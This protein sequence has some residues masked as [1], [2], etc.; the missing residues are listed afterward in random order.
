MDE[1][2]NTKVSL[3]PA[4]TF[5]AVGAFLA[6]IG[7]FVGWFGVTAVRQTAIFGRE[8]VR[9]DTR[10]GTEDVTGILVAVLG[11]LSGVLAVVALAGGSRWF[12]RFAASFAGFGGVAM[13]ASSALGAVRAGTVAQGTEVAIGR[14]TLEGT[15]SLGLYVSALAGAVAAVAGLLALRSG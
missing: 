2:P 11:G 10:G 8:I 7:V 6:V 5:A 4:M 15:A 3:S 9:S 12:R 14:I 1:A 13:V